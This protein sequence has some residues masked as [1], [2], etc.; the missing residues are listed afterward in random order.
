[1]KNKLIN[2]AIL[3]AITFLIVLIVYL[4]IFIRNYRQTK[5]GKKSKLKRDLVEVRLLKLYYKVDIDKLKYSSVLRSIS[6]VSSFDIAL[7]VSISCITKMGILQ[8]LIACVIIFPVIYI[9]YWLLAKYLKRKI[10][11]LEKKGKINNE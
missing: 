1:M 9:S 3:F 2:G 5:K 7:I 8:I 11:K 4:V 10:K 6:V